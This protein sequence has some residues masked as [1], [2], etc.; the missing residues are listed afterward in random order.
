MITRSERPLA[1]ARPFLLL[2]GIAGIGL[3][4]LA[5]SMLRDAGMPAHVNEDY[6]RVAGGLLTAEIPL[7]DAAALS[8]GLRGR[9]A[10]VVRVP[11]LTAHRF[12]LAGGATSELGNTQAAVAIYQSHLNDLLVWHA[13][14]GN[15]NALPTTNDVRD[16]DG[17]RYFVHRKAT[18]TLVFWQDGPLVEVITCGLPSEQVF[19]IALTAAKD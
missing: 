14:P 11:P 4:I 17:R 3:L 2:A 15:V 9:F 6:M 10:H 19:T 7:H 16:R 12:A 5:L 18:N 8:A 13:Y 1:R